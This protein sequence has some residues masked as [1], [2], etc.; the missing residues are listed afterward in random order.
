MVGYPTPTHPFPKLRMK[1]APLGIMAAIVGAV[2]I[3]GPLWLRAIVGRA[4]EN[5]AD[6][7]V[8]L[9]TSTS[10]DV[11]ELWN[12]STIVRMMGS[13]GILQLIFLPDE[14][15]K[16]EVGLFT[17]E[18]G[19]KVGKF[20]LKKGKIEGALVQMPSKSEYQKVWCLSDRKNRSIW[21]FEKY[22]PQTFRQDYKRRREKLRNNGIAKEPTA[23]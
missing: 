1:Q 17:L 2:R 10:R 16:P 4:K 8:E 7:E 12:G 18:E 6:A 19:K 21:G 15:N 23:E 14:W 3:G 11:C 13:P 5:Q 9:T 22:I 20:E